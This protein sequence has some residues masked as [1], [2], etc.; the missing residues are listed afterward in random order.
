MNKQ[1]QTCEV[2]GWPPI[3]QPWPAGWLATLTRTLPTRS[4]LINRPI[5]VLTLQA[6]PACN[7]PPCLR[8]PPPPRKNKSPS[9]QPG[10]IIKGGGTCCWSHRA[11]PGA[12]TC[13]LALSS[14]CWPQ[15]GAQFWVP[16]L[17]APCLGPSYPAFHPH[18]LQP[19]RTT[20]ERW[21]LHQGVVRAVWAHNGPFLVIGSYLHSASHWAIGECSCS[22][23]F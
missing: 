1:T 19:S 4:P 8:R 21:G 12:S 6:T 11:F 9:T 15:L 3:N 18:L 17:L 14:S 10:K 2:N 7:G 22:L 23:Q 20:A 16:P 13:L 5:H